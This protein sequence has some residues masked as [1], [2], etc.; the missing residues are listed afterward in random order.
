MTLLFRLFSFKMSQL[1]L[2]SQTADLMTV[3]AIISSKQFNQNNEISFLK[4]H[5][6]KI[7][8]CVTS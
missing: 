3:L 7:S 5:S 8:V 6:Q 1:L 4:K 2:P